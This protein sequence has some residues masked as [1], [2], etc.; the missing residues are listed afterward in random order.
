MNE[1]TQNLKEYEILYFVN[2]IHEAEEIKNI[3]QK[4]T[5]IITKNNGIIVKE[6]E[7]GK[8]KLAYMVKN[9]RHGHYILTVFKCPLADAEKIN[10]EL[11]LMPEIIRHKLVVK[12]KF[13]TVQDRKSVV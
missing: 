9:A 12:E 5:E 2:I 13:K 11:E 7:I 10:R 4:V 8:R 1:T 6:D 3:K